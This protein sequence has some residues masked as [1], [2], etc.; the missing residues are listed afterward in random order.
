MS[1]SETTKQPLG[2]GRIVGD[3][4]RVLFA[5]FWFF[6]IV[7]LL[8]G[9]VSFLVSLAML[10]P[11]VF[12]DIVA[13]AQA[14]NETSF[15]IINSVVSVILF[16]LVFTFL[17]AGA[18]DVKQ[19]V[20]INLGAYFQSALKAFFPLLI[21]TIVIMVLA[22]LP[23]LFVVIVGFALGFSSPS[24]GSAAAVIVLFGLLVI[25]L[26]FY[27]Y[28]CFSATIPAI[29]LEKAGFSALRR[30]LHLTRDYRGSIIGLFLIMVVLLLGL[31]F[32]LGG[33]IG[34][35]A[36]GGSLVLEAVS[37][38]SLLMFQGLNLILGAFIT[39]Y[40]TIIAA[41]LFM[42]L[43]EIKEGHGLSNVAEVFE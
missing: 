32:V 18:H 24:G 12:T 16:C 23:A 11:T 42:R 41:L 33:I 20:P 2:V 10:G 29:V 31:T 5:K 19:G 36:V 7:G 34:A 6:M 15:Q 22:A 14:Q 27:I 8:S 40:L 21:L 17:I 1:V 25:P 35:L 3:G 26:A 30:S 28:A 37:V 43:R 4:F 9:L 13:L 38:S 39:A